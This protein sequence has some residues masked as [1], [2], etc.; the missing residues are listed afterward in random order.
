MTLN[1]HV[2]TQVQ[3][4]QQATIPK[5]QKPAPPDAR[6]EM[7]S[8]IKNGQFKLRKTPHQINGELSSLCTTNNFAVPIKACLLVWMVLFGTY[9]S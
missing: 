5:A 2:G 9:K 8:A 4:S 7:L 6:E 3:V 1:W